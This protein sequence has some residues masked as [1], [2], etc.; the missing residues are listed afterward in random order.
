MITNFCIIIFC[1]PQDGV[2]NA[3]K[4]KHL[5]FQLYSSCAKWCCLFTLLKNKT[6]SARVSMKTGPVAA[7]DATTDNLK[8]T[9]TSYVQF[10]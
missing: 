8:H 4:R 3:K 10:I 2:Q 5:V 6:F 9:A 1:S 7:N